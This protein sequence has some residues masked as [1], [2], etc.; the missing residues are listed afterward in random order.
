MPPAG[1]RVVN[2]DRV[3]PRHVDPGIGLQQRI[4]RRLR[5]KTSRKTSAEAGVTDCSI[6][7]KFHWY[8]HRTNPYPVVNRINAVNAMLRNANGHRRLIIDPKC[9]Y[10]I[11]SLEGLTYKEGT[12]MPDKSH[13]LDHAGD[14]LGY[15]IAAIF[16][17]FDSN[18]WSKRDAYSGKDLTD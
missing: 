10:L 16:P 15:L 18:N 5:G 8:V 7:E 6:I 9:K 14:A 13:G 1:E 12:R 3:R 4:V 17:G 2:Y 11:R